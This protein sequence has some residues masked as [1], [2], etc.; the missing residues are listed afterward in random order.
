MI[1]P[2]PLLQLQG[3]SSFQTIRHIE[4]LKGKFGNKSILYTFEAQIP[5]TYSTKWHCSVKFA[6]VIESPKVFITP[7]TLVITIVTV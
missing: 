4:I 6:L 5:S 7:L 1:T 2:P 3:L